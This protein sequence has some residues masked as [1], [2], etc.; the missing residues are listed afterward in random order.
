MDE[1]RERISTGGGRSGT[2]A[3]EGGAG[4]R[5]DAR[6]VGRQ[7]GRDRRLSRLSQRASVRAATTGRGR[8]VGAARRARGHTATV[9]VGGTAAGRHSLISGRLLFRS[10]SPRPRV[11][12]P[13]APS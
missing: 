13:R 11:I 3:G 1:G 10:S 9:R 2:G 6:Q 7:A 4:R 12:F 5:A 8:V